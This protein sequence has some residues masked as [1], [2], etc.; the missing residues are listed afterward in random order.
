MFCLE[1][2]QQLYVLF[3]LNLASPPHGMFPWIGAILLRATTATVYSEPPGIFLAPVP[4]L[5]SKACAI[6]V[7]S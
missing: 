1:G 4:R 7:D 6:P 3:M 5:T 2:G